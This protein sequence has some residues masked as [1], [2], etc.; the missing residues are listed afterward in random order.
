MSR[1]MGSDTGREAP[2]R[3]HDEPDEAVEVLR[4]VW[5]ATGQTSADLDEMFGT[6]RSCK[7]MR[8]VGFEALAG[9]SGD[10]RSAWRATLER[11]GKLSRNSGSVKDL[12]L[13]S[14]EPGDR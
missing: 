4:G 7:N 13:G 12:V 14:A 8:N 2:A 9:T 5:T 11:E 3:S 6:P 1:E 10:M